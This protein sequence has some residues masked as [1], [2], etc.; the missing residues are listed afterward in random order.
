MDASEPKTMVSGS[1]C[2][3]PYS[4]RCARK[5]LPQE[6]IFT[7]LLHLPALVIRDLM[8]HVSREWDLMIRSPN[9]IH[10]HLL[11]ST[12]GIIFQ[13]FSEPRNAIYVEMR[14]GSLEISK[15]DCG[16]GHLHLIPTS[17]NGLSLIRDSRDLYIINPLTKQRTVL[18]PFFLLIGLH[19]QFKLAFAEASMEYKVVYALRLKPHAPPKQIAM[20]TVG[21][22]KVWRQID[23]EHLPLKTR[24]ALNTF[25]VVTGG[26]VHWIGESFV[27][28]LNVDTETFCE[29]SMPRLRERFRYFLPMGSNLSVVY[30]SSKFTRDVW[31]MNSKTGE[32]TML[33]SFDWRLVRYRLKGFFNKYR[34]KIVPI[35]WLAVRE[36]LAFTTSHDQRRCIAYNVKTTEIQWFELVTDF[37]NTDAK[38]YNFFSHVNSFVCLEG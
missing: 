7:I 36:V 33:L 37:S 30:G 16:S 38:A 25:P 17:C 34:E 22:D 24:I 10:C 23:V 19:S 27:L 9:F 3:C 28:T 14:G 12:S 32:W 18:P 35:G 4:K 5:S 1:R 20:L 13:R 31:E 2:I 29:F 21:V 15:F 11:N 26:Y 6:M 8:R